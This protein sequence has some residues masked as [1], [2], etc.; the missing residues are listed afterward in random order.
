M[1]SSSGGENF[2][3]AL[4]DFDLALRLK[5]DYAEAY[6]ARSNVRY[7]YFDRK[8]PPD[9]KEI[10]LTYRQALAD[11]NEAIRL[12]PKNWRFYHQ[13]ASIQ[14]GNHNLDAAEADYTEAIRLEPTSW[15][16]WARGNFFDYWRKDTSK[17]LGDFTLAIQLAEKEKA[18]T[19]Y[20]EYPLEW[21]Y[22]ERGNLYEKLGEPEK[23]KADYE[24]SK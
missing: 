17:A 15:T 18:K 2:E 11:I 1:A 4:E 3:K 5:P 22:R 9:P 23:A 21:L 13:R 8:S 24:K 10:D 14:T 20:P 12:D 19:S 16:Y 6:A 7:R